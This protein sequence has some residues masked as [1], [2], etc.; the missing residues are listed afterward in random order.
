MDVAK[1]AMPNTFSTKALDLAHCWIN[2]CMSTTTVIA[3][4][5]WSVLDFLTI[6]S[7]MNTIQ[8]LDCSTTSLAVL[9]LYNVLQPITHHALVTLTLAPGRWACN[10][11][12]QVAATR[13]L[14]QYLM[15]TILRTNV[16]GV[17]LS[18]GKPYTG[19][20]QTTHDCWLPALTFG[21]LP[22]DSPQLLLTTPP[23]FSFNN[24]DTFFCTHVSMPSWHAYLAR[25]QPRLM[26]LPIPLFSLPM[27]PNPWHPCCYQ[28]PN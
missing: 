28:Y 5:I 11:R 10:S 8:G 23:V 22:S 21:S 3:A 2:K 19:F 15:Q 1:L 20:G 26:C 18:L 17:S 9:H 25:A 4:V 27:F 13:E 16:K 6:A 24:I 7:K 12:I 14:S